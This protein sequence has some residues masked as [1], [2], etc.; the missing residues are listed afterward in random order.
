MQQTALTTCF[1]KC[2]ML[3]VYVQ[4]KAVPGKNQEWIKGLLEFSYPYFLQLFLLAW[5]PKHKDL[6]SLLPGSLTS[7]K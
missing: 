7:M 5:T 3:E 2:L 4:F 6:L 1:Y